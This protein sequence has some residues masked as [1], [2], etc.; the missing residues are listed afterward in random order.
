[1]I[2]LAQVAVN[3]IGKTHWIGKV[4]HRLI[5]IADTATDNGIRGTGK[6]AMLPFVGALVKDH[7]IDIPRL[8]RGKSAR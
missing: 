3:A 6:G 8:R 2:E 1:M 4:A 7:A 5:L